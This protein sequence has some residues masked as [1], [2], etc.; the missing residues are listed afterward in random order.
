MSDARATYLYPGYAPY[1]KTPTADDPIWLVVHNYTR[2]DIN[3]AANGADFKSAKMRSPD[4]RGGNPLEPV[5]LLRYEVA[6][7][8]AKY[9]ELHTPDAEQADRGSAT[10]RN[11]NGFDLFDSTSIYDND[12][13]K[14][15]DD[16]RD[17]WMGLQDPVGDSG[18]AVHRDGR[19]ELLRQ[20]AAEGIVA[21]LD[22]HDVP[23][24]LE[25]ISETRS[26]NHVNWAVYRD[27]L[28][29][30]LEARLVNHWH[31]MS[32]EQQAKHTAY[33]PP[34]GDDDNTNSGT[35]SGTSSGTV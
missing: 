23:A 8:P 13:L 7:H 12:Y 9:Y 1:A 14:A 19:A 29:K 25:I 24:A 17:W 11:P 27:Q 21:C 6:Y 31:L 32:P 16:F 2:R 34:D 33:D 5:A 3:K 4:G 18:D 28:V 20:M 30:L 15:R 26:I 35:N 10:G 22:N